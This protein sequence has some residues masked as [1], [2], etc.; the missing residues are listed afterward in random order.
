MGTLI[1]FKLPMTKK[2]ADAEENKPKKPLSAFFFFMNE[3][4]AKF[5]E[6]NPDMSMCQISK[7]LTEVWKALTEDEKKKYDDMNAKDKERYEKEMEA[8]GIKS[9]SAKAKEDGAAPKKA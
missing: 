9:K 4:R 6:D 8:A 5:K 1:K 2:G 3:R 7:G